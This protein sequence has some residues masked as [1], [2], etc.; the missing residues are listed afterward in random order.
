MAEGGGGEWVKS[1][2]GEGR[3][4]EALINPPFNQRVSFAGNVE[5]AA[6]A[7]GCRGRAGERSSSGRGNCS[8]ARWFFCLP[9]SPG[10]SL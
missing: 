8:H 3:G 6:L 10:W 4:T 7:L 1:V 9:S 5:P 2:W